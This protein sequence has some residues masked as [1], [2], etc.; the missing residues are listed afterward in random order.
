MV[1]EGKGFFFPGIF[2]KLPKTFFI[3]DVMNSCENGMEKRFE[4]ERGGAAFSLLVC[5]EPKKKQ[6]PTLG[7]KTE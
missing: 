3:F 6:K 5:R 7:T 2:G 4:I 1:R